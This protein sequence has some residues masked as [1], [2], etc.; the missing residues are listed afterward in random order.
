[1]FD[2]TTTLQKVLQWKDIANRIILVCP[3]KDMRPYRHTVW[4]FQELLLVFDKLRTALSMAQ[5][6]S[7]DT[8]MNPV[9]LLASLS[10]IVC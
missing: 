5:A 1:M 2:Q 3:W 4:T 9:H 8:I 7:G 10:T 6:P